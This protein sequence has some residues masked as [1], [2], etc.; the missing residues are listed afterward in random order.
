M[1]EDAP[2]RMHTEDRNAFLTEDFSCC[3][4]AFTLTALE[5]TL[6]IDGME[7]MSSLLP[8]VTMIIEYTNLSRY[9]ANLWKFDYNILALSLS[10]SPDFSASKVRYVRE[11]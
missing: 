1:I 4:M 5:W 3:F 9:T 10:L 11:L 7:E 8:E 2:E 6:T